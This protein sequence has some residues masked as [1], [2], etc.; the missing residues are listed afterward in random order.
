MHM[1]RA[2]PLVVGSSVFFLGISA[3]VSELNPHTREFDAD[4]TVAFVAQDDTLRDQL[5]EDADGL[6]V[7]PVLE[8]A[9]EPFTRIAVRFDA[10]TAVTVFG[11][12]RVDGTW[13]EWSPLTETFGDGAA[14]NAH[15]DVAADSDAAQLRFAVASPRE[16][17]FLVIETFVYE[18]D[19]SDA[20]LDIDAEGAQSE[21]LQG[22]AADGLV[23]TR[24]QWGARARNCGPSHTP[25][26]LTIHHTVT[27]NNDSL[28]M[29]ARVRQI[30][31][32]HI[33]NRGWC[34]IGY[35]FLIGQDGEV[36]QGRVENIIGA[37]AAGA[38]ANNVGISFVGTFT[39]SSPPDAMM[40]AAARILGSLGQTYG[41]RLDRTKVQG[42]RQVG[43][44]QT[45]CPGDA[46][47]A[48]LESLLELA[49]GEQAV[50]APA[51]PCSLI[52]SDAD[53]L[54]IRP[55]PN[56]SQA[57]VGALLINQTALRL[58]TVSGQSVNGVTRWF[59]VNRSGTVGFVSA[60]YASCAN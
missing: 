48:E 14:H 27:P 50:A 46:L 12:A 9:D 54:N 52:K 29:P 30:Q 22:L 8:R 34:D 15:L 55:Q 3:C 44:T 43:N 47:Y 35:H 33:N 13:S 2:A 45:S 56:T 16:L 37:H 36:Y 11:R 19:E 7:T 32:F 26:R 28:S 42:H 51:E 20:D 25:Q 40:Q 39:A 18:P 10:A 4:H 53:S 58:E 41:I 23:V 24:G 5:H 31:N 38:N 49:R 1:H 6:F 17:S 60:A 21:S 57:P 59:R